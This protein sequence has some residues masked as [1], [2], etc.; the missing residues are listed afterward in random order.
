MV[1]MITLDL[2]VVKKISQG[3]S[4][5]I[6]P[7]K[8]PSCLYD[9]RK[10]ILLKEPQKTPGFFYTLF[11]SVFHSKL[12]FFAI[13]YDSIDTNFLNM[14]QEIKEI[15]IQI[16]VPFTSCNN[17]TRF[18]SNGSAYLTYLCFSF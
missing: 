12:L 16:S 7:G 1:E 8:S 5:R 13:I 10:N 2:A 15:L 3:V 11:T 18:P 14:A 9:I 17:Q 4:Y 6:V